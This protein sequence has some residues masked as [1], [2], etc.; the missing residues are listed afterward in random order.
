ME[1]IIV[2]LLSYIIGSSSMSFYLGKMNGVAINKTGSKNLGASNTMALLGWKAGIIVG[3][4]DILK[5]VLVVM[6]ARYVY[7]DLFAIGEV[8]GVSCILGHIFPFYLKFKG[9]KG[10]AS[11]V[12]MTLALN[13]KF[14][15]ILILVIVVLVLIT[16][17]IVAGTFST[18]LLVPIILGIINSSFVIFAI[19]AVASIVMLF[20]HKDNIMRIA[21]GTEVGLRSAN[22]GEHRVK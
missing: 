20:K 1:Y 8:A 17:Y 3:L 15:L 5:A 9:G 12:G 4:H 19:L 7:G 13:W 18:M 11:Y 6:V 2:I 22:R 21:N 14:A 16:D 10:F